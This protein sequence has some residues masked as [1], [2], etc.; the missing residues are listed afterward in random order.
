[1]ATAQ[2]I[3]TITG[4]LLP[5]GADIQDLSLGSGGSGMTLQAFAGN[6]GSA[7]L[8]NFDVSNTASFTGQTFLGA[9]TDGF[10]LADYGTVSLNLSNTRLNTVL[11]TAPGDLQDATD[12]TGANTGQAVDQVALIAVDMGTTTYLVSTRPNEN[13][14]QSFEQLGGGAL[15]PINPAPDPSVGQFSDLATVTAY[16]QTWVLGSSQTTESVISYTIDAAG[17]LTQQFSFGAPDGLGVNTPTDLNIVLLEGQPYV[18][19]ASSDSNSLSVLRLEADGSFTPTDHILDDLNSRFAE[20]TVLE[21]TTIG[22]STFVL[23][24]GSDDGFSLFRLLNDGRLHLLTTVTDTAATALDN[25]S[26]AAFGLDGTDL[27][28]FFASSTEVG[29]SQFSYDLAALGA[30]INGTSTANILNGTALDDVIL[31]G[32]GDDTI[33]GGAGDDILIDGAGTDTLIGGAGADVF[34]FDPDGD[35]DTIQDFERGIDALNL[36]YFPLLYDPNTLGFVSTYYGA[37]L[38]FQGESIYIYSSDFNPLTLAELTAIHPFNV[39]RPA[40]VLGNGSTGNGQT[41]IGAGANDTL[42][43]TNGDDILSGNGGDDTLIGGPGADALYGGIGYDTANY[44]T[45]TSGIIFDWLNGALNTGDAAGDTLTSVEVIL[46]TGFDDQISGSN[47]ADALYGRNGADTLNGRDGDDILDGSFG[48]DILNGGAGADALNGGSEIDTASYFDA[49]S[50]LR[51]DL[52]HAGRNTGQADGD[53]YISIEDLTGSE[54]ADSIY[55]D[56]GANTLRGNGGDDWLVGRAGDDIIYG[57]NGND[58]MEGG[59]GADFLDGGAGTDRAQ[60]YTSKQGLTVNLGNSS[61]NTGMATG[62]TFSSIEDLAG[63]RFDDQLTGNGSNNRLIGNDGDDTLNGGGG[64]DILLAGSGD[65]RLIG[66]T[67]TDTL[68][69]GAGADVFVFNSGFSND[70]I[71]D[72]DSTGDQIELDTSLLGSTAANGAAVLT[73]FASLSGSTATLDFGSGDILQIDGIGDLSALTDVFL[74]V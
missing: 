31:A 46:G 10:T 7:R 32:A 67:G 48:N 24:S 45:A 25:V 59:W 56:A 21:T 69:G 73:D 37:S 63:S 20:P 28:M 18:V 61:A 35:D 44:G 58:V 22:D 53:S 34:T 3:Q 65:D 50:G 38:T 2:F 47:A 26:A 64:D 40:M 11:N 54:F 43:G 19:L 36:S 42:V 71:R 57:G 74:F 39:D 30:N 72:F 12:L 17:T 15:S 33:S 60:Y 6:N 49:P 62:D 68:F 4:P 8:V 5:Y 52:L 16:G 9:G 70:T 1:M 27:R 41:Q 29:I 23:A 51:M 66:D 55:G 13:G 14:L